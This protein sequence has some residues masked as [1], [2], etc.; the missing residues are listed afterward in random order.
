M[1][2]ESN[3]D[4]E[5]DEEII[6]DFGYGQG[7]RFTLEAFKKMADNF[8]SRWIN[9]S[10]ELEKE[11][12]YWRIVSSSEHWVQVQYG[13]DL[14][15]EKHQSGFPLNKNSKD[16]GVRQR[17]IAFEKDNINEKLPRI[18]PYMSLSGWNT[19]N[20]PGATFLHHINESVGGVTRPMIYVGM[21]FS[22]FCWHTE[23]NYLYSINYL[24]TGKPKL[25][26]G[27]PGFAADRFEA[28]FRDKFPDL[29]KKNPNL[30]HLLVTQ[31]PPKLLQE[32]GIPVYTTLQKAG[33]FIV[34]C[35]KAYHG[36]FNT[37]F[38]VAESVNFAL[39]DWLPF[40]DEACQDYRYQRSSVFPYEE[41]VLKAIQSPDSPPIRKQLASALKEIIKNE[42]KLRNKVVGL[43]IEQIHVPYKATRARGKDRVGGGYQ[44]CIDCGFDCYLSAVVCQSHPEHLVC[45][46]HVSKMCACSLSQKKLQIRKTMEELKHAEKG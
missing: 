36:G 25:W 4:T 33:Q 35:P 21:L 42:E 12:E 44:S 37:G 15:V 1:E 27:V 38:N 24:H 19:N 10:N 29:F 14:D 2:L 23:D 3:S 39:E 32:A 18:D 30:L 20:L 34:T 9:C 11:R 13:S 17:A 26:Y 41:F 16:A 8:E 5:S 46:N 28:L 31:L 43:G 22:S 6:T 7:Q 45:L 40:C